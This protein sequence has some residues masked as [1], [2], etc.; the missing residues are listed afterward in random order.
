[1]NEDDNTALVN[2]ELNS[3]KGS[4]ADKVISQDEEGL[5][6]EEVDEPQNNIGEPNEQDVPE[7]NKT[8]TNKQTKD[9]IDPAQSIHVPSSNAENEAGTPQENL[10]NGVHIRSSSGIIVNVKTR[11]KETWVIVSRVSSASGEGGHADNLRLQLIRF[12]NETKLKFIVVSEN[13]TVAK[14]GSVSRLLFIDVS[15]TGS[16]VGTSL[17]WSHSAQEK[18]FQGNTHSDQ[19]VLLEATE[20][21]EKG[22]QF[23]TASKGP[24]FVESEKRGEHFELRIV[25]DEDWDPLENEHLPDK[26]A[27]AKNDRLRGNTPNFGEDI[28][29]TVNEI[30]ATKD[31]QTLKHYRANLRLSPRLSESL[32]NALSNAADAKS[33]GWSDWGRWESCSATCGE[34]GQ[35]HRRRLCAATPGHTSLHYTCQGSEVETR[36]CVALP[37]CGGNPDNVHYD[38]LHN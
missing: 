25:Q 30:K 14:D 16:P 20:V 34:N 31:D 23:Q 6:S 12:P 15:G 17:E 11:R 29:L 18:K 32:S 8:P 36:H 26:F 24:M 35:T 13:D 22:T 10:V 2:I 38:Y 21:D 1:M 3:E 4:S 27:T 7:A 37:A 33:S 5:Q 19:L 28:S 9:G